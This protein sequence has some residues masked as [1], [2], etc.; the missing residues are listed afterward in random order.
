MLTLQLNT[1]SEKQQYIFQLG[2]SNIVTPFLQLQVKEEH[3]V[4]SDGNTPNA[5]YQ[6]LQEKMKFVFIAGS[7]HFEKTLS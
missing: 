4:L 1:K 6:K 3:L 7:R 2:N 5:F